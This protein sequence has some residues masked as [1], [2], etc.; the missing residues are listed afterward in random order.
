MRA[1]TAPALLFAFTLASC[2][3]DATTTTSTTTASAATASVARAG[4][5]ASAPRPFAGRCEL[6]VTPLPSSP[7]LV[8]QA[9]T[10]TCQLSHLGR[11]KYA[12][13][14][15]LDLVARTQRGERTL[16]AANGDELRMVVAGTSTPSGPGL[17]SFSATFTIVGGTGR[18][19]NATGQG[20]AEGT[21][22]L[23]TSKTSVSLD[24]WVDYDASGR[25]GT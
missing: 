7:P 5:H 15:E 2:A 12:G 20:R 4:G 22:N 10:G 3:G 8:R 19:A 13:V 9:D 18:F 21:A 6:T 16:T 17:V 23:I 24:G 1:P 11:T 14:L 25:S